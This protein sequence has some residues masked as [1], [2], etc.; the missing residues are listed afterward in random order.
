[1]V[2]LMRWERK[3]KN[4]NPLKYNNKI[5]H[6]SECW[7]SS[8]QLFSLSL[9]LF[10][11]HFPNLYISLF[12]SD[13]TAVIWLP[14]SPPL[15]LISSLLPYYSSA[16]LP[17]SPSQPLFSVPSGHSSRCCALFKGKPGNWEHSKNNVNEYQR[18]WKTA[19]PL[20]CSRVAR[21]N[22]KM[23]S[24]Q[25]LESN[26]LWRGCQVSK[27]CGFCDR[28]MYRKTLGWEKKQQLWH[29]AT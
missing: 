2:T 24:K 20:P 18:K 12:L 13:L 3:K 15:S 23:K 27:T 21:V 1:M 26:P 6:S 28:K 16:F 9:S 29:S 22:K 25:K 17:Y 10:A 8:K 19:I 11:S 14:S 4:Q 5:T 7:G